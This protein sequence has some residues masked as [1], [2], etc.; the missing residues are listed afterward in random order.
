MYEL[1]QL[2]SIVVNLRG[3]RIQNTLRNDKQVSILV[4]TRNNA[5]FDD[6]GSP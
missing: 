1:Q 4:L 5:A 6:E 3:A 2:D